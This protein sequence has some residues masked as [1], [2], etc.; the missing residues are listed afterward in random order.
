[1]AIQGGPLGGEPTAVG[2]VAAQLTQDRL[3]N[4]DPAGQFVLVPLADVLLFPP[5]DVRAILARSAGVWYICRH[6]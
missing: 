3:E 4:W 2:A 6:L 5:M 1:M